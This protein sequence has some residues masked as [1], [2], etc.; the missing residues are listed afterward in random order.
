MATNRREVR[1]DSPTSGG[2]R[3]ITGASQRKHTADSGQVAGKKPGGIR[4]VAYGIGRIFAT[5]CMVGIITACIV[6]CVVAVYI[7]QII[8]TDEPI[9]LSE[10]RMGYTSLILAE[11]D[12]GEEIVLARLHFGGQDRTWVGL[13]DISPW[14]MAAAVAVEDR[15]FWEHGGVDW[16]RTAGAAIGMFAPI[17]GTTT[18]GGSTI[19]QQLVKNVTGDDEFRVD[20]K[21]Q[22]IFRAL[23]LSTRYSR[24]DI[25][26]AYLNVI[27]LGNGTNGIQAAAN[28]YFGVDAS[29]LTIAQSAAL[30]G[31]TQFPG[32]YNPYTNPTAHRNRQLHVMWEMY[33]QGM[34]TASKHQ[35]AIAEQL[36]LRDHAAEPGA[37]IPPT[38]YFVDHAINETVAF[39]MD[40]MDMT[41]SE[42]FAEL[43]SGGYRVYT[44]V[45]LEMQAF[46]E[47][48][49]LTPERFPPVITHGNEYPQSATVILNHQGRMLA[50]VG[51]IGEK[52]GQLTF[53][54]ATMSRRHPGSA[55][56]PIGPFALAIEEGVITWSTIIED[57][58]LTDTVDGWSPVNHW[59]G[60]LGAMTVDEAM[61]RS[62]NTVAAKI[63]QRIGP[64]RVFDFMENRMGF[65]TLVDERVSGNMVFTDVALSPMSLGA[66]TDG[67]SPLE[68]ALAYSTFVNGGWRYIPYSVYRIEDAAGNLIMEHDPMAGR[69]RA[70]SEE[71]SVIMTRMMQN[72]VTGQHGTGSRANIPGMPT[73]GKTGTSQHN[74]N[75]WFVGM[76][77]HY[78][79]PAWL[80]FDNIQRT[81]VDS[82]GRRHIVPNE[83]GW[84]IYPPPVLWRSVMEPLHQG[85]EPIPFLDSPNVVSFT[86]CR[87]S[88]YLAT[89]FCPRTGSGWYMV[90]RVPAQCVI[91]R[92]GL[93]TPQPDGYQGDD[94]GAQLPGIPSPDFLPDVSSE[95]EWVSPVDPGVGG[96]IPPMPAPSAP[97]APVPVAT[98][99]T[100][101]NP[102]GFQPH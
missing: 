30:I 83:V 1:V 73:A 26:E 67:V 22:E 92:F 17:Y 51:G 55:I 88:G 52:Q 47:D 33:N 35:A 49:F 98:D 78:V 16:R 68:M 59:G 56:K 65:T 79:M 27:H 45:D 74:T 48:F 15:R 11:D 10:V 23:D 46:L 40:S 31:I 90:G 75:Q 63:T 60:F 25:L 29:E 18:G 93:P 34:I 89:P 4:R 102:Q 38:S 85:L 21:I 42:A 6:V 64:D 37:P 36:V 76:T 41:R 8:A 91:H 9:S 99:G 61:R 28:F 53:N 62:V 20:R 39:F 94:F 54:R 100:G 5:F 80:G 12:E 13:D 43:M 57:S 32:R 95:Y 70:I 81:V 86:Y 3:R 7:L 84:Q 50:T 82:N 14:V 101:I 19:T 96:T 58:P 66:L 24:E 87:D 69:H 72:V 2:E 71:T 97:S 77:P 44:T